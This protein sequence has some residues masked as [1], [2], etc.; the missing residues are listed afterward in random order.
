MERL[1]D[2]PG[3]AKS[4]QEVA[5]MSWLFSEWLSMKSGKRSAISARTMLSVDYLRGRFN[6]WLSEKLMRGHLSGA[7]ACDAVRMVDLL[8]SCGL[9]LM[10]GLS[11]KRC[12]WPTKD[13][14][15]ATLYTV[16]NGSLGK[17]APP[18]ERD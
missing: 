9:E 7:K 8:D 11:G 5:F 1:V 16:S 17:P 4:V 15:G 2:N 6:V 13:T 14:I 3:K 10:D 18:V 12:F